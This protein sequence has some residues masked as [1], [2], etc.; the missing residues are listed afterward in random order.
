MDALSRT[1]PA[2][3]PCFRFRY[4]Y[5]RVVHRVLGPMQTCCFCENGTDSGIYVR[6]DP[7]KVPYPTL[8]K[9]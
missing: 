5:E 4:G 2:C 9:D 1:Q 6:V 8:L 3:E 7:A